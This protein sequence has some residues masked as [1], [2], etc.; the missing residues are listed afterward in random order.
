MLLILRVMA[1]RRSQSM[2]SQILG[3]S[4]S[5]PPILK[6]CSREHMANE[7]NVRL[8]GHGVVSSRWRGQEC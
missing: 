7:H 5:L 6:V 3:V 2:V 4:A 8:I 1:L